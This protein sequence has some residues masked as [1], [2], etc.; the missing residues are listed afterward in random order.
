MNVKTILLDIDG[1]ILDFDA[2]EYIAFKSACELHDVPFTEAIYE[3]YHVINKSMWKKLELGQVTKG[4]LIYL[5]FRKLFTEVRL[6]RDEY[7]FEDDYQRILAEGCHFMDG[8]VEVLE[9]LA[10]KY[11]L[12]IVTNGVTETQTQ[13]L[14]TA[15]IEQYVKGI[16]ISGNIGFD[17]P[18]KEYFDRCFEQ[19]GDVDLHTTLIIGDSLSSDMRGGN[20]AGILTCWYNPKREIN[21]TEVTIDYEIHHLKELKKLL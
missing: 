15:G 20:H 16:F 3:R 18:S 21:D 11:A 5:R 7:A 19:I 14:K 12:Y 9:Y 10:W 8:A 1:T 2:Y 17:K 6:E 4:E 13:K